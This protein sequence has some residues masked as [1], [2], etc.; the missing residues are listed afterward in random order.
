MNNSNTFIITVDLSGM[1]TKLL[2]QISTPFMNFSSTDGE[3]VNEVKTAL[4]YG[5]KVP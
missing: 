1:N 4:C 5:K 3:A 2:G